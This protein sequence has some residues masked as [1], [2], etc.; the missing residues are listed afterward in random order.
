MWRWVAISKK[1]KLLSKRPA[2]LGLKESI[3]HIL[4]HISTFHLLYRLNFEIESFLK[5]TSV[6]SYLLLARKMWEKFL[7][8]ANCLESNFLVW[9]KGSRCSLID[10]AQKRKFSIEDFFSRRSQFRSS[11]WIW[12]HLLEKSLMENFI[13]MRFCFLIK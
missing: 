1:K 3:C 6:E 12:S 10:T 11:L 4:Q 7:I 5:C 2:L 9:I 8:D 13:F